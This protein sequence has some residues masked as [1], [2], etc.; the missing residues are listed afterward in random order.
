VVPEQF[1]LVQAAKAFD[2]NGALLDEKHTQ[3]VQRVVDS[4]LRTARAM[5]QA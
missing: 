1:A 2:A 5:Q 4:V 3:A